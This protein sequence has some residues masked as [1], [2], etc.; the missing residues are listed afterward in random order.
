MF[1]N[2]LNEVYNDPTS[3]NIIINDNDTEIKK[4]SRLL[5]LQNIDWKI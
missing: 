3:M 1:E 2:G 4:I 5:K